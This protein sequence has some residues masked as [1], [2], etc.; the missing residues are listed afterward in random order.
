MQK[1]IPDCFQ[2]YL[3]D[4][5]AKD[6]KKTLSRTK[7]FDI[8]L[9][10]I[11]QSKNGK[12]LFKDTSNPNIPNFY[13]PKKNN[14]IIKIF[15]FNTWR[16]CSFED[17]VKAINLF[18]ENFFKN[19]KTPAPKLTGIPYKKEILELNILG[20]FHKEKNELYINFD[21][22][23]EFSGIKLLSIL[24]HE[25]SHCVDFYNIQNNLIPTLLKKYWNTSTIN[26]QS[27]LTLDEEIKIIE[28]PISGYIFNHQSQ[29]EEFID[30][31][32]RNDILKAKN[33]I[34]S[35]MPTNSITFSTIKTKK[36]LYSY[37]S[38]TL[39]LMSPCERHARVQSKKY[40][41]KINN[42]S[43]LAHDD[44]IQI[45]HEF[46]QDKS[47]NNKI[48]NDCKKFTDLLSRQ[49][50]ESLQSLE[51]WDTFTR[52]RF[53]DNQKRKIAGLPRKYLP[54]HNKAISNANSA[55]NSMFSHI[56][57]IDN[58]TA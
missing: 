27:S 37:I 36:D 17:K 34:V 20:Y 50:K 32:L 6:I 14:D 3:R 8:I 1:K 18:V 28:L 2:K 43:R 55:L 46:K 57:D 40:M 23:N 44:S 15:L 35:F 19:S 51:I 13:S 30:N 56:D 24:Y 42:N 12:L 21:K 39:Y 38:N 52:A 22:I 7:T 48:I 26:P 5:R 33:Y 41:T 9:N 47:I 25:C 16:N 11:L 45:E 4:S 53:Y 49:S 31:N 54:L 10:L 29:K 58:P